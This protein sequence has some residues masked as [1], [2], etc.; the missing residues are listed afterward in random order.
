MTNHPFFWDIVFVVAVTPLLE[1]AILRQN[2]RVLS[3]VTMFF[4][5]SMTLYIIPYISHFYF[6]PDWRLNLLDYHQFSV[7]FN[8][9]RCFLYTYCIVMILL[10]YRLS[11]SQPV[12]MLLDYK[13]IRNRTMF[14]LVFFCFVVVIMLGVGVGFS[15][16]AMIDRAIHPREYTYIKGGSGL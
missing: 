10:L 3:P 4:L 12:V 14:F 5:G 6:S 15:P 9:L 7:A 1:V 2:Y 16:A 11:K 13:Q 8:V